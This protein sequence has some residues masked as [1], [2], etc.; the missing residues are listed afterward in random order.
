MELNDIIKPENLVY[1]KH[2]LMNENP[3]NYCPG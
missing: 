2:R 1:E 3:M